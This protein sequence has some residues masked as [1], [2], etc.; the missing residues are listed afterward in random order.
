L[1]SS[2]YANLKMYTFLLLTEFEASKPTNSFTGSLLNDDQVRE[3][4]RG[5][6]V[7]FHIASYIDSR[8][9]P[10]KKTLELI[11]VNGRTL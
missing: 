2:K 3:A 1:P 9:Q 11:N 5:V 10:D 8:F 6:D 7:V 4:C